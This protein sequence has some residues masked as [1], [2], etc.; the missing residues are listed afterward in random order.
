M[1][2]QH[3][4]TLTPDWQRL[5]RALAVEAERGFADLVGREARFSE[6]LQAS[7]A[8]LP[9]QLASADC[10]R[11]QSLGSQ[12]ASYADLPLSQRQYLVANT[13][14]FLYQLQRQQEQ[15]QALL[16][17]R[18]RQSEAKLRPNELVWPPLNPSR[19]KLEPRLLPAKLLLTRA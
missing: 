18:L 14:R 10:E 5:Q 17:E 3:V 6:F 19:S 15:A 12:F 1:P 9:P 4:L 13:R 16:V 11:W 7:L 8:V 2:E